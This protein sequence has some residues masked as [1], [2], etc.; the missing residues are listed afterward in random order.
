MVEEKKQ[1][2]ME[3]DTPT[4]KS[5]ETKKFLFHCTQCGW[6]CENRGPIPI[7]FWDL[8]MWAKNGVL[9]N[10]IPYLKIF[11]TESGGFDLILAP[12]KFDPYKKY[13]EKQQE[14]LKKQLEQTEQKESETESSEKEEEEEEENT[15]ETDKVD[16]KEGDVDEKRCPLFNMEKRECLVYQFRPLSCRTYPLEFDGE[17]YN[18]V[19][20]DNCEGIGQGPM[21]KEDLKEMRENAK[22]T[23]TEM[24]TMQ[25]SIPV[26]FNVIRQDSIL[27]QQMQTEFWYEM[28]Q[29]QLKAMESMDPE[30]KKKLDEILSRSRKKEMEEEEEEEKGETSS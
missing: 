3:S 23:Y 20:E 27:R 11:R 4:E 13:V 1:T 6:C 2:N 17:G 30:D 21:T 29:E 25:I 19:D 24:K 14:L 8:E 5:A 10:F 7:T 15:T 12:L 26:L 16:Q 22:R 9:D 18:V 28:Y